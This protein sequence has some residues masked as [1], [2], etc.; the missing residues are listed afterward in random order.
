M[1]KK[2]YISSTFK[3]LKEYRAVVKTLFENQLSESFELC[4]IMERMWDDGS[5]TSFV[6]E[7]ERE[8]KA[9]DIYILI[10]GNK[11]GSFPPNEKRT[12]TEIELDTALTDSSKKIYM[13][14]LAE[15]DDA[16]IDQKEKH[17]EIRRKSDG[18]N[19]HFFSNPIELKADLLE[20]LLPLVGSPVHKKLAESVYGT[21]NE[22]PENYLG[23]S[24][25]LA[26]IGSYLN[27]NNSSIPSGVAIVGEGGLGKTALISK[28]FLE[29]QYRYKY[30]IFLFCENGIVPELEKLAMLR[31][32]RYHELEDGDKIAELVNYL[33]NMVLEAKG[34][35]LFDNVNIENH[36]LEF[37]KKYG[38]INWDK[39]ITTRIKN[40]T[41]N[42]IELQPLPEHLALDLF[43][44]FYVHEDRSSTEAIVKQLLAGMFYNTLLIEIFAKVLDQHYGL[45]EESITSFIEKFKEKG[46]FE[47]I[48]S[49]YNVQ[50]QYTKNIHKYDT[51]KVNDILSVMYDVAGLSKDQKE[52]LQALALLPTSKHK[53]ATVIDLFKPANK[54]EFYN[55]LKTLSAWITIDNIQLSM[56]DL[57]QE[58]LLYSCKGSFNP[59]QDNLLAFLRNKMDKEETE[60]ANIIQIYHPLANGIL[61]N[62]ARVKESFTNSMFSLF[63]DIQYFEKNVLKGG[64]DANAIYNNFKIFIETQEAG[65]GH[66]FI[67]R[68]LYEEFVEICI[69]NKKY[70]EAIEYQKLLVAYEKAS[71]TDLKTYAT[72]LKKLISIYQLKFD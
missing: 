60:V 64:A 15:F 17:D 63:E 36:W 28:Y 65:N 7:C 40:L 58:M 3:D 52:I 14:H 56:K 18:K 42:E 21:L 55:Q 25:E 70:I 33:N 20:C 57:V 67:L 47:F 50:T 48:D 71:I 61:K 44:S 29:N 41:T 26:K 12:Y 72:K 13:F 11:V 43:Y 35:M 49:G 16:E 8:V 45:F 54:V 59:L 2:V 5:Q 39:L 68:N 69:N 1:K 51:E 23:R 32:P 27:Q 30:F 22:I 19:K 46:L 10:L 66:S 24:E 38:L 34:I 53:I 37:K 9:A 31:L 4:K 62:A 6:T